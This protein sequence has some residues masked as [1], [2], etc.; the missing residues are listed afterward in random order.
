MPQGLIAKREEEQTRKEITIVEKL[1]K[2]VVEGAT[3]QKR[4]KDEVKAGNMT[5]TKLVSNLSPIAK[6]EIENKTKVAKPYRRYSK[7]LAIEGNN[8]VGGDSKIADEAK[9]EVGDKL[10]RNKEMEEE[11]EEAKK[12]RE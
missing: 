10:R 9:K 4:E 11:V 8:T 12:E 2:V 3:L 1:P 7:P 6:P 5:S